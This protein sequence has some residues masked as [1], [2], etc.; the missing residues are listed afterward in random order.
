MIYHGN[1]IK[2]RQDITPQQFEEALECFRDQ[3]RAIPAV[4]WF[5]LGPEHNSDF[6]WSAIFALEDV[7]AYREY[8]THPAHVKT[9]RIGIPLMEK[10]ETFDISDTPGPELG[11]KIAELQKRNYE[12]DPELA[13]LVSGL[14]SH[15]GSS[16]V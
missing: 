5:I 14:A 13:K 1:R 16:A 9:E 2:L 7:D 12:A 6:D 10:F 4:K 15:T 11:A 3:G 8:L